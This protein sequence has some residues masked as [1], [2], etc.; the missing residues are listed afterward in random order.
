MTAVSR[1]SR[2]LRLVLFVCALAL[3]AVS[4][5]LAIFHR[6]PWIIPSSEKLRQNPLTASPANLA[7]AKEIYGA[8]C[9]DCHGEKGKGDGPDAMMYDPT[10][11]D[12]TDA[13][14]MNKLTDGEIFYQITEGRKP[15]PSFRK[16]L[17]DEQRWQLVLFVRSLPGAPTAQPASAT[18]PN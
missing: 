14:R 16:K 17:S 13:V 8:R 18:K 10:P 6:Q 9:E 12:L 3:I 1:K 5:G 7:A 15:M 2:R 4:A 11:S